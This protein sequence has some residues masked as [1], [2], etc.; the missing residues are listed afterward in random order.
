MNFESDSEISLIDWEETQFHDSE[1]S[2]QGILS[3]HDT[4]SAIDIDFESQTFRLNDAS[5]ESC[6]YS[7]TV[8]LANQNFV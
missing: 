2:D 5:S 8:S 3:E 7:P 4:E 6:Y 1:T